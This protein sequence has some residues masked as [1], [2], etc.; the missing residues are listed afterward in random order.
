MK[1]LHK[2]SHSSHV[3]SAIGD[4]SARFWLSLIFMQSLVPQL[5]DIGPN[6]RWEGKL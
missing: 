5:Y 6:I 4:E 1:P 3:V 2:A